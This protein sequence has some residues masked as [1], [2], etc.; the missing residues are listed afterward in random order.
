MN[1]QAIRL[2]YPNAKKIDDTEGVFDFDGNQI[3][4]DNDLVAAKIQ[5]LQADYD[6]KQY[7]RDRAAVYP[8]W[9]DQL[10]NIFHN[11]IDAWEAD[12]QAIK[13]QFPKP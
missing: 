11:G 1:H 5:E 9:Q 6:S 4:I 3:V 10:D 8:S 12:I 7:Q 2:V 13:D